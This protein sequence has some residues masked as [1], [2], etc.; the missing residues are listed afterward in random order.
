MGSAGSGKTMLAEFRSCLGIPLIDEGVRDWLSDHRFGNPKSL[1]WELQ[2]ELQQH[3]LDSKIRTESAHEEFVSD[4]TTV[5]AVTNLLL[6]RPQSI[7]G[8]NLV[9]QDFARRALRHASETYRQIILL[10][11]NGRPRAMPDGIRETDPELLKD[12]Y[13]LSANLCEL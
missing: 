1:S 12:E 10:Q 6:R 5:D 2:L 4:R 11:W 9:P 7:G 13:S 3:Y 8:Q